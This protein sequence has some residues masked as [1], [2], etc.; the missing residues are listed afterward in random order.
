MRA[1]ELEG[2]GEGRRMRRVG[3]VGV[4]VKVKGV[5]NAEGS[6]GEWVQ[7]TGR[8]WGVRRVVGRVQV[9]DG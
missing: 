1:S 5:S 6:M 7:A 9:C 4:E 8:E 2:G 3:V